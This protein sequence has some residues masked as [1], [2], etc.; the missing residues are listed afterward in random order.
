MGQRHNKAKASRKMGCLAS[1][2][3]FPWV[4]Q[5]EKGIVRLPWFG[6]L[7]GLV[8]SGAPYSNGP[9]CASLGC[10]IPKGSTKCPSSLVDK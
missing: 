8:E 3:G 5:E 10:V 1:N 7:H 4:L 9:N 2:F 6:G